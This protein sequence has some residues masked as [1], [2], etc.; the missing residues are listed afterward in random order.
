M[1]EYRELELESCCGGLRCR[2]YC[3]FTGLAGVFRVAYDVGA[4]SEDGRD[5]GDDVRENLSL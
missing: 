3:C 1:D 2:V 4:K 5:G